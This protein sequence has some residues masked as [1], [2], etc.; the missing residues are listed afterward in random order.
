MIDDNGVEYLSFPAQLF[1]EAVDFLRSQG[2]LKL[3]GSAAVVSTPLHGTQ[4]SAVRA[5]S[6]GVLPVPIF[7]QSPVQTAQQVERTVPLAG[8]PFQNLSYSIPTLN[9]DTIISDDSTIIVEDNEDGNEDVEMEPI[10]DEVV[11]KYN[12]IASDRKAA[13][14]KVGDVEKKVSRPV[15]I[16]YGKQIK[17]KIEQQAEDDYEK[18]EEV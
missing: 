15:R 18:Y 3:T 11:S 17:E 4:I 8:P 14:E 12:T 6:G 13:A 1:V 9:E 10:G 7:G 2:Y 5:S 16:D